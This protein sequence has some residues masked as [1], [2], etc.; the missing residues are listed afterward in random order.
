MS[1]ARPHRIRPA[2]LVALAI[3]PLAVA[4]SSNAAIQCEVLSAL[5][6]SQVAALSSAAYN[7]SLASYFWQQEQQMHPGCIFM[8][9]AVDDVQIAITTLTAI[10]LI[11]PADSLVAIRSGGHGIVPGASNDNGGLTIDL[12]QLDDITI[13]ENQ[14]IVSIGAGA[15]WEDVYAVLDPL[16]LTVSGGRVAGIGLGGY[17]TGGTCLSSHLGRRTVVPD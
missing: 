4:L 16:N 1:P 12:S 14:T 5:L 17:F 15:R 9:C 10:F 2:V 7:A 13:N 6:P 11:D 8:P 3:A